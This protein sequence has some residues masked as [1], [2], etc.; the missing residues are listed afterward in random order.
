VAIVAAT[1][2]PD[3]FVFERSMQHTLVGHSAIALALL[4]GLLLVE[5]AEDSCTVS[6]R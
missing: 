1:V 4:L 6:I 3:A 5:G 2:V